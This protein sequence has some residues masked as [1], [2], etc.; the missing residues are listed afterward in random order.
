MDVDAAP[1]GGLRNVR[2]TQQ[3]RLLLAQVL[4]VPIGDLIRPN[5]W[6]SR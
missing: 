6:L 2:G 4:H 1:V 3:G 5:P